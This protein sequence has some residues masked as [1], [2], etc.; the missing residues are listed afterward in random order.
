M[1]SGLFRA[2]GLALVLAGPAAA[3]DFS[4]VIF[5]NDRAVTGYELEQRI[6]LL[7]VFGTP[8]DLPEVARTQLVEE[9]L[10]AQE[11]ERVGVSLT[12]EGLA[13]ALEDFAAR[14]DLSTEEF[15]ARLESD[16]IAYETLRDYV[17]A[18]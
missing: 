9:R 4:P 3:Q 5:V 1:A 7:E 6:R 14:A 12:E 18:N 13:E 10:K 8:G 11:L 15:V 17:E 16:G 2:L